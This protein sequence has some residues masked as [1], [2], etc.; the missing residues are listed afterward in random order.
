MESWK[1]VELWLMIFSPDKCEVMYLGGDRPFAENCGAQETFNDDLGITSYRS[2]RKA[3]GR[4]TF[5]ALGTQLRCSET[6]LLNSVQVN[7][8][9]FCAVLIATLCNGHN[10][11]GKDTE[12]IRQDVAWLGTFQPRNGGGV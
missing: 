3:F 4:F 5:I 1:K 8:G 10:C 9:V 11:T 6:S 7:L 2:Q 12:E